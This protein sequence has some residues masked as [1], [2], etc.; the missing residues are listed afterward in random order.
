MCVLSLSQGPRDRGVFSCATCLPACGEHKKEESGGAK[1]GPRRKVESWSGGD[2]GRASSPLWSPLHIIFSSVEGR[3]KAAAG[4]SKAAGGGARTKNGTAAA[5]EREKEMRPFRVLVPSHQETHPATV[6]VK[7]ELIYIHAANQPEN[8]LQ[9]DKN[10]TL[11]VG[12]RK[13]TKYVS[14]FGYF[15]CIS[16]GLQFWCAFVGGHVRLGGGRKYKKER[17]MALYLF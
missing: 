9:S 8:S 2:R 12:N 3:Q 13:N 16:V 15:F 11:E 7:S 10:N 5:T 17:K 4:V 14:M 1:V 6:A